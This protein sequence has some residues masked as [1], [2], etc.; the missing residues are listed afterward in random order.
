MDASK[1]QGQGTAGEVANFVYAVAY[2][3]HHKDFMQ[4]ASRHEF[5]TLCPPRSGDFRSPEIH[6]RSLSL[7]YQAAAQ[8]TALTDKNAHQA[9]KKFL[10]YEER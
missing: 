4:L 6:Y 1:D 8:A 9:S 7:D 2:R 3:F 5:P 10:P